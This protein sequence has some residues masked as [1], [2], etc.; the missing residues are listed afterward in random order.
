MPAAPTLLDNPVWHALGTAQAGFARGAAHARRFPADV[1]PFV[2]VG[3]A[4]VGPAALA[5]LLASGEVASFVGVVP[6]LPPAWAVE[7]D[8]PLLQMTAA[9]PA[10]AEADGPPIVRLGEADVPDMLA[11]TAIAFPGYFRPRTIAMGTYHGIRDGGILVAMA[12]E[13]LH[14]APHREISGVCTHPDHVGRGHA[15]RLVTRLLAE[16]LARG[17]APFLHVS[18]ENAGAIRV[19]EA[20]GF[21]PRRELRLVRVRA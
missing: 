2:A 1:A 5:D 4:D 12:G 17:E 10:P 9:G 15:R 8:G 7:F 20:L 21:A 13:R 19:Y 16:A 11:L 3:T 6:A 18:P 14:A